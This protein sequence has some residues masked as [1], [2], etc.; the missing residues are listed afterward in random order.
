MIGPLYF[1]LKDTQLVLAVLIIITSLAVLPTYLLARQIA[2]KQV[3]VV[4][5][6]MFIASFD[7]YRTVTWLSNPVLAAVSIPFFYYFLWMVFF[8][9]KIQ[10]FPWLMA[11][12]AVTHQASILFIPWG[13]LVVAG[14]LWH[15]Q[16]G[17]IKK[18]W[19]WRNFLIGCGVYALGIFS[20]FIAQ[21][22]AWKA[23]LFNFKNL[24]EF[25]SWTQTDLPVFWRTL[26]LFLE[27]VVFVTFPTMPVLAIIVGLAS[28]FILKQ[29]GVKQ[30]WYLLM[31]FGAPLWI[32]AFNYRDR[33]YAFTGVETAV[34]IAFAVLL[35]YLWKYKWKA[36]AI[37]LLVLYFNA[38][39][40]AYK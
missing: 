16:T 15:W 14:L 12:L 3:A 26:D 19:S 18:I 5:S 17:D 7:V 25:S 1:L 23:G 29:Q 24:A 32:L 36:V 27:K 33:Y 34:F 35:Q 10:F 9:R 38:Q 28:V 39:V 21:V 11:S 8:E 22:L 20:M 37:I 30:K 40:S 31:V 13:G 6:L 4:T 2:G